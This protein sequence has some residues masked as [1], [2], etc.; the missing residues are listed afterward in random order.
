MQPNVYENQSI[1]N[2]PDGYVGSRMLPSPGISR[3]C[4][5]EWKEAE[6]LGAQDMSKNRGV[7][8]VS[9]LHI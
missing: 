5:T 9:F 8:R 2:I 6:G 7:A 1:V 4:V 3:R